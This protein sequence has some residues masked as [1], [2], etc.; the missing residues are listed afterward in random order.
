MVIGLRGFSFDHENKGCEALTYSFLN[1]LNKI[2]TDEDK[3]EIINIS[4][5]ESLGN[6]PKQFPNMQFSQERISIKDKKM[7][8]ISLFNRCDII[9]DI[10]DGDGFSD[11]YFTNAVYKSTLLTII[12]EKCSCRYVML[13]QTYGPFKHKSLEVLAGYAI[14]HANYVF[15]RDQLS[16][17]YAKKISNRKQITTVTDLAFALPFKSGKSEKLKTKVGI[18]VSGLL[19]K[20][21]FSSSN[22]FSLQTEY[23]QYTRK[24]IYYCCEKGYEIHLIS[25]VTR[26]LEDD[27][28]SYDTDYTACMELKKEFPDVI[29]SPMYTSPIDVKS[30][31]ATMDIFIGARM[32]ATI[33]AFS[34]GVKTIPFAY[35][36]KFNGLYGN[37]NYPYV[38]DGCTLTTEQAIDK[39]IEYMND[40]ALIECSNC[41]MKLIREKLNIFENELTKILNM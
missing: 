31:I 15:S 35:S 6:V 22:Q 21:G 41:A 29:V 34:S 30:Y 25:H 19:W 16:T 9:F 3:I 18:N 2:C 4:S 17:D 1:I 37:L 20:G 8:Y 5:I 28:P 12:A 40:D 13:P 23:Q 24:L 27:V 38:V 10:Y 33:A 26:K 7:R 36:R 39:T 32:H 11:I 14:R